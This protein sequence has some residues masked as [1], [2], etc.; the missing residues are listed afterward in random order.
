VIPEEQVVLKLC[1]DG[2][3]LSLELLEATVEVVIKNLV[4][5]LV[6]LEKLEDLRVGEHLF[7]ELFTGEGAEADQDEV[8]CK[9]LKRHQS[10]QI[11]VLTTQTSHF[12]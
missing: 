3:Q 11:W 7:F 8:E 12:G 4:S 2:V 6:V 5:L 9:I 10:L 1:F